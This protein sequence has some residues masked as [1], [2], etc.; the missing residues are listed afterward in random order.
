MERLP[1]FHIFG[2]NLPAAADL[3]EKTSKKINGGAEK[4]PSTLL[5]TPARN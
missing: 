5:R 1:G 2:T 3:V 4:N